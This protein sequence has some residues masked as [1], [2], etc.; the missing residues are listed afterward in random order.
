DGFALD[1]GTHREH[2]RDRLEPRAR[3]LHA[4]IGLDHR[5]RPEHLNDRPKLLLRHAGCLLVERM[6]LCISVCA[7][8]RLPAT[9]RWPARC[10]SARMGA[11]RSHVSSKD[12]LIF[13][14]PRW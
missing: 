2:A 13:I 11:C 8:R 6:K 7:P 9:S 12:T 5:L 14:G 1:I 4:R 3:L 10:S